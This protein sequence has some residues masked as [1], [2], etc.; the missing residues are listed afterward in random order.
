MAWSK[1]GTTIRVGIGA[2]WPPYFIINDRLVGGIEVDILDMLLL[3][4]GMCAQYIKLPSPARMR[5]EF[6]AQ[7][8]DLLM[9]ISFNEERASLGVFSHPYRNEISR[10]LVN[11]RNEADR[12]LPLTELMDKGKSLVLTRETYFGEMVENIRLQPKYA[13]QIVYVSRVPQRFSLVAAGH[14][15]MTVIDE[16]VAR[17]LFALIGDADVSLSAQPLAVEPVHYLVH[18]TLATQ[19]F[20]SQLNSAIS[21]NRN[22]IDAILDRVP[23]NV[24]GAVK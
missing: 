6:V 7:R 21:R 13:E 2:H 9:A 23:I 11:A 19:A 3:D 14:T 4:M 15:D 8:I 17:Y 24:V 10:L 20:V 5:T 12:E 16:Q 1:C 18:K 22:K